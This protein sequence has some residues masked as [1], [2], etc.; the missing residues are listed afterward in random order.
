MESEK[1]SRR[2]YR[3]DLFPQTVSISYIKNYY[4]IAHLTL[5]DFSLLSDF[6]EVTE[7]LSIVIGSFVTL[8]K[9]YNNRR[10]TSS[11]KGY[12][13]ISSW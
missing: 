2:D 4:L 13:V 8:G 12:Y 3:S 1:M 9:T 6:E 5:A 7:E 10:K 11:C